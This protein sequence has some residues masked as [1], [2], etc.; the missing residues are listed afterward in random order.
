MILE[1]IYNINS[2]KKNVL[3]LFYKVFEKTNDKNRLFNQTIRNRKLGGKILWRTAVEN[4][5]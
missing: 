3:L 2:N 4:A 5:M 1:G